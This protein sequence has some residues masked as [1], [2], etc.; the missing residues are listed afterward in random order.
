MNYQEFCTYVCRHLKDY[1]PEEYQ[2]VAFAEAQTAKVNQGIQFGFYKTG[3][4][5]RILTQMSLESWYREYSAGAAP[6]EL[7][8]EIASHYLQTEEMKKN[9]AI[10]KVLDSLTD[11]NFFEK[12]L[13][14][15]R[16]IAKVINREK[17]E[18]ILQNRP[19]R[20]VNDLE[21]IYDIYL[22]NEEIGILTTPVTERLRERL[23]LTEE[24]LY[25][26]AQKN[27][28]S[29]FPP[30]T[31]GLMETVSRMLGEDIPED[32][33]EEETLI[34]TNKNNFFGATYLAMPQVLETVTEDFCDKVAIIPSSLHELLL[35]EDDGTL[36]YEELREILR[37]VNEEVVE[38]E[39][40][41]SDNLYCYDRNIGQ[42]QIVMDGGENQVI[43][44]QEG[45]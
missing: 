23:S 16:I 22:N 32:K 42:V 45:L 36:N 39:D 21:L 27:F 14:K 18:A 40:F 44:M 12:D 9:S 19:H 37:S 34:L 2:N 8:E 6:E 26:A 4:S 20:A 25:Q 17:N 5:E 10:Q 41:L 1:L 7:M 28:L 3:D 35:V 15:E 13:I 31:S 33:K 11:K 24:E 30:V 38:N 43:G 29:L